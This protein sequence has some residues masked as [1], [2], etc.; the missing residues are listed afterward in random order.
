M[1]STSATAHLAIQPKSEPLPQADDPYAFIPHEQY[2]SNDPYSFLG[3]IP[4]YPLVT[5]HT[6][7]LPFT[8]PFLLTVST[9]I[10]TA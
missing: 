6:L 7:S 4:V 8:W 2:P 10:N 5:T 1:P 9:G 3:L